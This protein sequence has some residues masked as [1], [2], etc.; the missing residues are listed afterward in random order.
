[1]A[2][3]DAQKGAGPC[4]MRGATSLAHRMKIVTL[5]RVMMSLGAKITRAWA[6]LPRA[7]PTAE[8]WFYPRHRLVR[9][10]RKRLGLK[11]GKYLTYQCQRASHHRG[12]RPACFSNRDREQD[13][14]NPFKNEGAIF[15]SPLSGRIDRDALATPPSNAHSHR[16]VAPDVTG[17]KDR[18]TMIHHPKGARLRRKLRMPAARGRSTPVLIPSTGLS[19]RF[20]NVLE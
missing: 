12:A 17:S 9:F 16:A 15:Q 6:E 19:A 10:E 4:S 8:R 11:D 13:D 1:M 14:E 20:G 5:E 18:H 7:F 2:V 3:R